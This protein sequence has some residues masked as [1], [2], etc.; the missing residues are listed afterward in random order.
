[1]NLTVPLRAISLRAGGASSSAAIA[2]A[3]ACLLLTVAAGWWRASLLRSAPANGAPERWEHVREAYPPVANIAP[4]VAVLGGYAADV[5]QANPF[6]SQRRMAPPAEATGA[7]GRGAGSGPAVPAGPE[8]RYKGRV[9]LGTRERAVLED[10]RSKKTHFLEV[11]QEVAG[12]K[13]LDID[14]KRVILSEVKTQKEVV[15]SLAATERP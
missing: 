5:I 1:M 15:V 7:A 3:G 10:L 6:S 14:E 11:G 9:A 4:P 8:F 13:V 2:V 12:F